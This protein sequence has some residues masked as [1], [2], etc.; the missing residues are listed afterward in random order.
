MRLPHYVELSADKA[1][2]DEA[3]P[4]LEGQM[5]KDGETDAYFLPKISEKT[6]SLFDHCAL[7]LDQSL[8]TGAHGLPFIGTG[9]WNDGMNRI[10]EKGKGESIWLG[11]FL[12]LN[13]V[14]FADIA[15]KRQDLAHA[16]SWQDHAKSL[17]EALERM[18]GM[19]NG[20]SAP[21]S[22]MEPLLAHRP[23]MNAVLMP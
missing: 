12:Y 4:Y 19:A 8:A 18:A 11:W 10:G 22:T 14:Q 3:I 23:T 9:D 13:L 2:L 20:I 15:L 17:K 7:A 5:L 1:I 21:I 6:A 16:K